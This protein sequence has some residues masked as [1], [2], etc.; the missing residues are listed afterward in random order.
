[1][2]SA[3]TQAASWSVPNPA[4][5]VSKH[6]VRGSAPLVTTEA[7][8]T[9]PASLHAPP[10]VYAT[11]SSRRCGQGLRSAT[12]TV[13]AASKRVQAPPSSAVKAVGTETATS[14]LVSAAHSSCSCVVGG[15]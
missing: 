5:V 6:A 13:E 7:A 14:Q 9:P 3:S 15:S 8:H 10:W 1:M 2:G 4:T 12:A 11:A